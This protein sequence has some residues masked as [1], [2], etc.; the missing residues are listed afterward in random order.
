MV[1]WGYVRAVV[2]SDI[3]VLLMAGYGSGPGFISHGA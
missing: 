1:L 2:L 3:V